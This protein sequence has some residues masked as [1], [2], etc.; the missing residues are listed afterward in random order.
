MLCYDKRAAQIPK[1]YLNTEIGKFKAKF[2]MYGYVRVGTKE[3]SVKN[4]KSV[5]S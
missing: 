5:I 3:Q 1:N 4:Q 2:M